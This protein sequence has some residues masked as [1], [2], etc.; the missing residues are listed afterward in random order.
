MVNSRRSCRHRAGQ[1]RGN[2]SAD[3]PQARHVRWA[4]CVECRWRAEPAAT[5]HPGPGVPVCRALRRLRPRL[6]NAQARRSRQ[7]SRSRPQPRRPGSSSPISKPTIRAQRAAARRVRPT[8]PDRI[9]Q[10]RQ[11]TQVRRP[12]PCDRATNGPKTRWSTLPRQR[13][14]TET[15]CCTKRG[16]AGPDHGSPV[17]GRR[18]AAEAPDAK[19]R[20]A[21]VSKAELA[22][23]GNDQT[24]ER[25]RHKR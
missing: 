24:A 13:A 22:P 6:P 17:P 12:T 8:Q 4:S 14:R 20:K 1:P 23:V 10:L 21:H 19:K 16:L 5:T 2:A 25:A 18:I 15:Y 11:L 7:E 9:P 3:G